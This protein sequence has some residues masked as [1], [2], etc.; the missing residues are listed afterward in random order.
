MVCFMQHLCAVCSPVWM[1]AAGCQEAAL[2]PDSLKLQC[3]HQATA[4]LFFKGNGRKMRRLQERKGVTLMARVKFDHVYKSF[5][6]VEVVHDINM[7]I[8]D[9]EFLV[10]VG[11]SGC[12]KSTCL[13]MIAGLEDVTSGEI[14]I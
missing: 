13:R 5:N 10:L 11:P 1:C 7:D 14:Y 4:L 9:K 3:M 8:A 6:K 12:G 2:T